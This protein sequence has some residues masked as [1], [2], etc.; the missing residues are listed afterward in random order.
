MFSYTFT[1]PISLPSPTNDDMLRINPIDLFDPFSANTNVFPSRQTSFDDMMTTNARPVVYKSFTNYNISQPQSPQHVAVQI[2][3][4][5]PPKR[6]RQFGSSTG[7]WRT[8]AG[9]YISAIYVGKRR[10]YGPVRVSQDEAAADRRLMDDVK[11]QN[12]NDIQGIQRLITELKR[13]RRY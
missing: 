11:R 2:L 10:F 6:T 4:G 12:P 7:V 1:D 13:L 8:P 3:G 9:H 5:S